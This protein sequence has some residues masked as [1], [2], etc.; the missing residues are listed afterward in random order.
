MKFQ[1]A[2]DFTAG[3]VFA[4]SLTGLMPACMAFYLHSQ[5]LPAYSAVIV[6]L[7]L[8]LTVL[9]RTYRSE[10]KENVLHAGHLFGTILSSYFLMS[11]FL[12]GF[13]AAL[14]GLSVSLAWIVC[15]EAKSFNV[16]WHP[17]SSADE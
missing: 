10:P 5:G 9:V 2:R 12:G 13:G 7:A 16:V 8:S 17:T 3:A 1:E 14:G 11:P 4:T 15:D 6:Q